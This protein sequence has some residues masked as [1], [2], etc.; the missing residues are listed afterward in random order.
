MINMHRHCT[1]VLW[2]IMHA[3]LPKKY[4]NLITT[5]IVTMV[6]PVLTSD[7]GNNSG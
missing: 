2:N 4:N 6:Y 5:Y 7:V 1:V 3:S